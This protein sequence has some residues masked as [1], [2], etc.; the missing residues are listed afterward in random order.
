MGAHPH[1]GLGLAAGGGAEE[2]R[3][4]GGGAPG[5]GTDG[6]GETV[7]GSSCVLFR[8]PEAGSGR[9]FR[10]TFRIRGFRIRGFRIR[11]LPKAIGFPVA[12]WL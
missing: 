7:H 1:L 4:E 6:V 5:V 3:N 10:E 8:V 12:D 2:F 11:G 9:R